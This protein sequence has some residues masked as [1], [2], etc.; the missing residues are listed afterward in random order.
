MNELNK[1]NEPSSL[2]RFHSTKL[3]ARYRY[4]LFAKTAMDQQKRRSLV[5]PR[6]SGPELRH[7]Y[8]PRSDLS[9]TP[10]QKYRSSYDTV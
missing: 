1:L 10:L 7:V 8:L 6:H 9:S 2:H 4:D 3:L 5:Y